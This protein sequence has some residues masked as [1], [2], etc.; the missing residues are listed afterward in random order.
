MLLD[1]YY[2]SSLSSSSTSSLSPSSSSAASSATT[3]CVTLN[4]VI[5]PKPASSNVTFSP[6]SSTSLSSPSSSSFTYTNF[7]LPFMVLNSTPSLSNPCTASIQ[8]NTSFTYVSPPTNLRCKLPRL[9]PS[10]KRSAIVTTPSPATGS[11]TKDANNPPRRSSTACTLNR[12]SS[13]SISFLCLSLSSFS[14]LTRS[15]LML[16]TYPLLRSCSICISFCM[17]C[18]FAKSRRWRLRMEF[19]HAVK[20]SGVE[21]GG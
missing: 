4:A 2:S 16:S 15:S 1:E 7:L 13:S 11:S 8:L 19:I 12:S 20:S 3:I 17:N 10:V 21:G 9:P 6:L 14:S 18:S 5:L